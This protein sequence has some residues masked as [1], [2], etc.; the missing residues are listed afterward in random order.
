MCNC[1][2]LCK[3]F[4]CTSSKL[5]SLL[6]KCIYEISLNHLNLLKS[7]EISEIFWNQWN[8]GKIQGFQNQYTFLGELVT[9][10]KLLL[11]QFDIRLQ[12]VA[13]CVLFM[14][15]KLCKALCKHSKSQPF[16]VDNNV[17]EWWVNNTTKVLLRKQV[18]IP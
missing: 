3:L 13:L 9:P 10:Q 11:A 8:Q 16:W 6:F 2:Q 4:M 12:M 1:I 15:L 7:L 5:Y 14:E 17:Q 18:T